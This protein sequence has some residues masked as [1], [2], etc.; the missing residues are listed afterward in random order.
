MES[1]QGTCLLVLDELVYS[2]KWYA[3]VVTYDSS[4][5]QEVS[6]SQ[7]G[8]TQ[9]CGAFDGQRSDDVERCT[10]AEPVELTVQMNPKISR[11]QH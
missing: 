7:E 2:K 8:P 1:I 5:A 6:V 4:S 10:C 11:L 9:A 3:P